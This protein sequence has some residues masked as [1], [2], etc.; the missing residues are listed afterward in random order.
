MMLRLLVTSDYE[1]FGNGSGAVDECLI[2][3]TAELLDVCERTGVMVALFVDVAELWAF[4]DLDV[5]EVP[6]ADWGSASNRVEEQL[7]EVYARG[8]DVQLHLHPQWLGARRQNGSWKVNSELWRLPAVRGEPGLTLVDLFEAGVRTLEGLLRP[9]DEGYECRAFRAGGWSIQPEGDAIRAMAEA[10]IRIDTS[11]AP[12]CACSHGWGRYRFREDSG[13]DWAWWIDDRVDVAAR[14]GEVLEV[15]I[16]TRASSLSLRIS[17]KLGRLFGDSADR[18]PGCTGSTEGESWP[19]DDRIDHALEQALAPRRMFDLC[20]PD[21]RELK[22]HVF[23]AEERLEATAEVSEAGMPLTAISHPKTMG[24]PD[25]LETFLRWCN[26]RDAVR[27]DEPDDER[28]WQVSPT[29]HAHAGIVNV[30]Q[31]DVP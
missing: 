3:P 12:G 26:G 21:S 9:V 20:V 2:R 6:G 11:V 10:G 16:F 18:P 28:F 15:P 17:R 31:N 27:I 5:M 23:D 30:E 29:E 7:Q 4:R 14:V 22:A 25:V 8:H 19:W 13:A 24:A 1:L